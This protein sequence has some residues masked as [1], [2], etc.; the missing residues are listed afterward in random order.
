MNFKNSYLMHP[1]ELQQLNSLPYTEICVSKVGEGRNMA[2]A[3]TGTQKEQV[4][5]PI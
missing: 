1:D 2:A 5:C 4:E 3:K